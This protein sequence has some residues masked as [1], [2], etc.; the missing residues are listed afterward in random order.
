MGFDHP[1]H[2]SGTSGFS[3]GEYPFEFL[4]KIRKATK[5]EWLPFFGPV[6][7]LSKGMTGAHKLLMELINYWSE[8][9]PDAS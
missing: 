8:S 5:F 2:S 9:Q 7:V 6:I 1:P 3:A 4:D